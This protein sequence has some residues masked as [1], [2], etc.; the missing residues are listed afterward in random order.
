MTIAGTSI[1]IGWVLGLVVF[2]LSLMVLFMKLLGIFPLD[3]PETI[4]FVFTG[5]LGLAR[6][7]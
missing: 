6:L 5:L 1:S 7:C 4:L 3:P 2:I